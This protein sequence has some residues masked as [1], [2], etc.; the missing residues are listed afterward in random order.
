MLKV[1]LD[2]TIPVT[3]A[4]SRLSELIEKTYNNHFWVLT[5]GG[6]PRAALVDVDY[7]DQLIRRAAFNDLAAQSRAAFDDYLRRR[8]F[9]PDTISEQAAEAIL[10]EE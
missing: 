6:K 5:K 4:R 10:Q 9:D 2:Q 1:S 8:G 7:L 3:Q